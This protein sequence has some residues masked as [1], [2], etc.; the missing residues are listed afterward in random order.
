MLLAASLQTHRILDYLPSTRQTLLFSATQTKSVKDLARLSL[1]KPE[2]ISVDEESKTTTPENLQQTYLTCPLES[3]LSVLYSFIKSHLK[4]KTIVFLSSCSQ[5]RY[6]NQILC[7]LQPGTPILSL[8]GK[9]KQAKRTHIYF[10]FLEKP[11]AVLLCTDVASRGLDFPRV[12]W[13]VQLDCPEGEIV[14]EDVKS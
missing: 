5:V 1:N 7:S 6:L 8:H 2:Y 3:K 4:K 13:V 14:F 11:N 12:D 10:D 9:I